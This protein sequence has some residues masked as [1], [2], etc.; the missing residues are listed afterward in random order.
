[1]NKI[2]SQDIFNEIFNKIY[3]INH[4][5]F[6]ECLLPIKN[7]SESYYK[8]FNKKKNKKIRD[9]YCWEGLKTKRIDGLRYNVVNLLYLYFVLNTM[10]LGKYNLKL[11]RL[12][13]NPDCINPF[14]Y[15]NLKFEDNVGNM[16]NKEEVLFQENINN[17]DVTILLTKDIE[18]IKEKLN[19][20]E[21]LLET[22]EPIKQEIKTAEKPMTYFEDLGKLVIDII[23]KGK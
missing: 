16:D 3:Y 2:L 21:K 7:S 11:K 22:K 18:F 9:C 4:D 13:S 6:T 1:M 20:I 8:Y 12:C 14:H 5:D 17:L 10:E 23:T 19:N 15:V